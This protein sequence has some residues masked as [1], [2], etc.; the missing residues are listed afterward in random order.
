M[1]SI[2]ELNQNGLWNNEQQSE[3]RNSLRIVSQLCLMQLQRLM[4]SLMQFTKLFQI[5]IVVLYTFYVFLDFFY[6][7]P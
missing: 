3:C 6:I 4:Q 1:K 7:I 2:I 5:N